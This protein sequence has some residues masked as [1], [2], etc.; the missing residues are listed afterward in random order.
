MNH[1]NAQGRH[2]FDREKRSLGD[3]QRMIDGG[4]LVRVRNRERVFLRF[5]CAFSRPSP[6]L[7]DFFFMLETDIT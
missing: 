1:S 7:I 6:K 4:C 2:Y 5:L 3:V